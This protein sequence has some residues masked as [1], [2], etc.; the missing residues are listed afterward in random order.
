MMLP[1][2]A[3]GFYLCMGAYGVLRAVR[4]SANNLVYGAVIALLYS[5]GFY[6]SYRSLAHGLHNRDPHSRFAFF[7][8]GSAAKNAALLQKAA[9]GEGVGAAPDAGAPMIERHEIGASEEDDMRAVDQLKAKPKQDPQL[10]K[11]QQKGEHI[12]E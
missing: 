5:G 7:S 12:G 4:E 6:A 2:A 11:L 8:P 3:S 10:L 1:W 9:S